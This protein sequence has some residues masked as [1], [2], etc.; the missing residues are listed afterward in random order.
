VTV[1]WPLRGRAR[2]LDEIVAVLA[3]GRS[4]VLHGPAG[5]GKSRLAAEAAAAVGAEQRRPARRITGTAGAAVP[6]AAVS[7]LLGGSPAADA[8]RGVTATLTD[9]LGVAVL[10]VDDAHHLDDASATVLHQVLERGDVAVVATRRTGQTLRPPVAALLASPALTSVGLD[11]LARDD[12]VE[13]LEA[14]LGGPVEGGTAHRL[15]D[16]CQGN[17]LYLREM[18][19]G[20]LAAG[21]LQQAAGLWRLTGTT[22]AT[23]LLDDLVASRLAPLDAASREVLELVALA[24]PV[25][26]DLLTVVS[27]AHRVEAL[28]RAALLVVRDDGDGLRVSTVHPLHAERLLATLPATTR[29]RLSRTLAAATG[30]PSPASVGDELQA[31]VWHL[32]GG[33]PLPHDRLIEAARAAFDVG[34]TETAARLAVAAFEVGAGTDAALLASWCLAEIG[35]QDEGTDVVERAIAAATDDRELAFLRMRNAE[36][37]WWHA[38]RP[39]QAEATLA[40]AADASPVGAAFAAAQ[41]SV[42]AALSGRPDDVVRHSAGLDRHADPWVDSTAN[43]ALGLA[44]V[45][46]GRVEA[47]AERATDA[48]A[49]VQAATRSSMNGDPGVHVVVR[50]YCLV[51]AGAIAEAD[52]LAQLVYDVA[53]TRP[54]RQARAWGAMLRAEVALARGRPLDA[55]RWFVEAEVGWA[56]GQLPGPARWCAI[57][58]ALAAALT[59]RSD[60]VDATLAR[61]DGYDGTGFGI[62]DPRRDRAQLWAAHLQGDGSVPARAAVS[63]EQARALGTHQAALEQA[64]DLWRLGFGAEAAALIGRPLEGARNAAL[65]TVVEAS[66]G[67]DVEAVAAAADDLEAMGCLLDAAEAMAHVARAHRRAGRSRPAERAAARSGALAGRCPGAATPALAERRS[68][69]GVSA[70]ELQVARLAASGMT[71]RAIARHLVVSERTVENHLYRVFTKLGIGARDELAAALPPEP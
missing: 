50:T 27:E 38:Q 60:D 54:G 63:V 6:L 43:L 55:Q 40:A 37:V 70:R 61:A 30:S 12:V 18:V 36:G 39:D 67:D 62:W 42:F 41:R 58:C 23:P 59:G 8:L 10:H 16:V 2:E 7:G 11:V 51:L 33:V 5:V 66:A 65:R 45:L 31:V 68:A 49:R 4:V 69:T 13:L 57:G 53:I 48:F 47:G 71:N 64:H 17:P 46:S 15:A 14:V 21:T 3:A 20:S 19:E 25:A 32:D 26:L 1:Q 9:G 56:D 28:E 34:D 24:E 29:R 35:Y 22:E 52:E 44:D